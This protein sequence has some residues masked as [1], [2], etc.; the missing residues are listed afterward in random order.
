MFYSANGMTIGSPEFS[1]EDYSDILTVFNA[2]NAPINQA[3]RLA[4]LLMKLNYHRDQAVRA[5]FAPKTAPLDEV[6]DEDLAAVDGH[7][8]GVNHA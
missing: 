4:E 8:E 2:G 5:Q 3:P 6:A 1:A 7:L